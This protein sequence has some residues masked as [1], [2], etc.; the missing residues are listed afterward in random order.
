MNAT[1]ELRFL[2]LGAQREGSRTFTAQLAPLGVTP[3]QA[4]V[5]SCLATSG[6]MSLRAL[7]KLLVCESGSP[8][9]L[10][11]TV[12]T[13]G[14]VTRRENPEDRR[15]VTLELTTEGKRLAAKIREVEEQ[16]YRWM[17]ERLSPDAIEA[18]AA[19]L[20]EVVAGTASGEAIA[21]R[22]LI[23]SGAKRPKER[24]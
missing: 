4:E 17:A 11:D 5:I 23:P 3:A 13:R 16:L 9:R 6:P 22:K 19:P 8:S 20:R 2:I 18:I 15:G 1:E 12:V 7:G 10:V 14:M 24:A 21:R